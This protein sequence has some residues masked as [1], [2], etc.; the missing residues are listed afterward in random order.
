MTMTEKKKKKN[1]NENNPTHPHTTSRWF[2]DLL[3]LVRL[4]FE[5]LADI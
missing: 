4:R 5:N 1:Y 2:V 3:F